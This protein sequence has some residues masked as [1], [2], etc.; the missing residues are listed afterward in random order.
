MQSKAGPVLLA[1]NPCKTVNIYGDDFVKGYKEKTLYK[2]HVYAMADAA[3]CDM[4]KGVLRNKL[5][6]FNF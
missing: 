3:F 4:M 5:R 1:I 6:S 2:P